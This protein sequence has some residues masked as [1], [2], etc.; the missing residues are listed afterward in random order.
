MVEKRAVGQT[1]RQTEGVQGIV[2]RVGFGATPQGLDL[3]R[4][5]ENEIRKQ[6]PKASAWPIKRHRRAPPQPSS[7]L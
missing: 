5:R 4:R 7:K 3:K 1:C 6:K 2:P